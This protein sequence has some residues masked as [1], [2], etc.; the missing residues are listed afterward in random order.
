MSFD[1]VMEKDET[2]LRCERVVLELQDRKLSGV[3]VAAKV[4]S[5]RN[6]EKD[7]CKMKWR[8]NLYK[9]GRSSR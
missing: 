1:I 6:L 8:G 3:G 7:N 5:C 2:Y 4:Y 9:C